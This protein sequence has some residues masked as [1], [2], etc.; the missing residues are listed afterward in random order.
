MQ[1]L[2]EGLAH[3]WIDGARPSDESVRIESHVAECAE[4]AA[5]VA[6]A[7]GVVAGA[8][9][10]VASLDVARGN[11]VP[12]KP[13]A[14]KSARPR[15]VWTALHLTPARAALAA[16][17]MIAVA[18]I[19]TVRQAGTAGDSAAAVAKA[20]SPAKPTAGGLPSAKAAVV[21]S[22]PLNQVVATAAPSAPSLG[23]RGRFGA[24]S[25]KANDAGPG[26]RTAP[27]RRLEVNAAATSAR[28]AQSFAETAVLRVPITCYEVSPE[29][30]AVRASIPV[31]FGLARGA[32]GEP[33]L[34]VLVSATGLPDSP[35]EGGWAELPNGMIRV[36]FASARSSLLI[37]GL[38]ARASW[39]AE[40]AEVSIARTSCSR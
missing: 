17:L 30:I 14:G 13:V 38:S 10:I 40:S 20:P 24:E 25:L 33:N 8:S 1:H 18:S 35:I 3:A 39:G 15:S 37:S 19:L 21:D 2:D 9:R 22:A 6:D 16:T 23:A 27:T 12:G 28:R 7:R 36:N 11:V 32:N 5:L 29:S 26:G 4:C 31:R 34:V